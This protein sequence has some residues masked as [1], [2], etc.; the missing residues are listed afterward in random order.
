MI[1]HEVGTNHLDKIRCPTPPF[2]QGPSG[3]GTW[4]A[5]SVGHRWLR[6]ILLALPIVAL[7]LLLGACGSVMY[8]HGVWEGAF[9]RCER[10][11]PTP[12][13]GWHISFDGEKDVFVCTYKRG[14]RE[15]GRRTLP[16]REYMGTSGSWPVFPDLVAHELEAIDG[17]QP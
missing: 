17:D 12:A 3:Y 2:R 6:R 1:S 5:G 15:V 10:Y 11:T 14:V 4:H 13:T 8:L 16:P 7:A 9:Q